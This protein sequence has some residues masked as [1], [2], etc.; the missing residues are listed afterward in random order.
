M[1]T[2]LDYIKVK[3]LFHFSCQFIF[4]FQAIP[5]TQELNIYLNIAKMKEES[6]T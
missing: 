1:L 4:L 5:N 2:N 6:K 3:G